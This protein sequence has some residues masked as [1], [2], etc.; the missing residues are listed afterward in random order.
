MFKNRTTRYELEVKLTR[1]V[2]DE[3]VAR[4]VVEVTGDEGAGDAVLLGEIISFRANPIGFTGEATADKYNIIVVAKII[5]RDVAKRKV[6]YSNPN[7]IYQEEYEV[8]EGTDFETVETEAVD[9]I[10]EKFA[11]SVVITIL[12]GF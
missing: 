3:F 1:S 7:F 8:P 5:L 11:R 10:A 9:K 6:I 2:I 4:G 12:E